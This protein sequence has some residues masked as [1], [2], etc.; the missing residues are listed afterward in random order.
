M[1]MN[2]LVHEQDR[3]YLR[4]LHRDQTTKVLKV[5]QATRHIFGLCSSPFIAIEI[6]RATAR[7]SEDL[8]PLAAKAILEATLV[9]DV[10]TSVRTIEELQALDQQLETML[11]NI[12]M[13]LHKKTSNYRD[14]MDA[15]PSEQRATY[16]EIEPLREQ[17][18]PGFIRTLG[19][20]YE[21]YRDQFTF[22]YIPELPTT[23]TLRLVVSFTGRLYDPLGFLA[24]FWWPQNLSSKPFSE[25]GEVGTK[26]FRLQW[27]ESGADG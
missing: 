26:K 5:Y 7:N 14:F 10:L 27:K 3:P 12:G 21:S 2:V 18:E 9:D 16:V 19:L 15:L 20:I 24:P 17:S 22:R 8:L 1:Y 4:F 23:G 6:V 13:Q 11:A 25:M